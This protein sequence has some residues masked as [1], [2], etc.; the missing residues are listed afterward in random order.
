M[1]SNDTTELVGAVLYSQ[2]AIVTLSHT[3]KAHDHAKILKFSA[4]VNLYNRHQ[5]VTRWY[6][7]SRIETGALHSEKSQ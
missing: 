2:R 6:L 3:I 5:E 4:K 7:G 1:G